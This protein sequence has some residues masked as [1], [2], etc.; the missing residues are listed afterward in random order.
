MTKDGQH[1]ITPTIWRGV[2]GKGDTYHTYVVLLQVKVIISDHGDVKASTK[3][4][5][6]FS[7]AVFLLRV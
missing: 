7:F 3:G 4:L 6:C 1:K 5:S 2:G